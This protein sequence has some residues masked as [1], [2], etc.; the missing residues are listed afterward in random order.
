MKFPTTSGKGV[1]CKARQRM[2]MLIAQMQK[3]PAEREKAKAKGKSEAGPKE[4][5]AAADDV[6]EVV[7]LEEE[8]LQVNQIT[9]E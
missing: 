2:M 7:S 8:L 9:D 3:I 1:I 4:A 6:L 5:P